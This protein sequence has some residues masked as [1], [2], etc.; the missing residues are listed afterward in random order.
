MMVSEKTHCLQFGLVPNGWRY[1]DGDSAVWDQR[2]KRMSRQIGWC[3]L[4]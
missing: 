4:E 3:E 2:G 1:G